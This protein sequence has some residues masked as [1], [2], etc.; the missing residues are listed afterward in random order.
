G[1]PKFDESHAL[2][3]PVTS[4]S[5]P[6]PQE[7]KVVKNDHMIAPRMFMINHFKTSREEKS[8]PNKPIK[9]SVRATPIIVSQPHVITKKYVNFDSNGLSSTGIDNTAKTRRP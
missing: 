1:L 6:T 3:K 4:N 7:S 9:A 5:V 8:V 2:S